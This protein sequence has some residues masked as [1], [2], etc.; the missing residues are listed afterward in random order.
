MN[1]RLAL[2]I[3]FSKPVVFRAVKVAI[4]VG[5]ILAFI[6]HGGLIL[7]KRLWPLRVTGVATLTVSP[8]CR[9]RFQTS[10]K[11]WRDDMR[12]R[13]MFQKKR[14]VT[15]SR[16]LPMQ[17][18]SSFVEAKS[19][20]ETNCCPSGEIFSEQLRVQSLSFVLLCA[21]GDRACEEAGAWHNSCGH[22]WGRLWWV[23]N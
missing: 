14:T 21:L 7:S 18:E 3:F 19:S 10:F 11:W 13:K 1:L 22:R 9:L 15:K 6:N 12:S 8:G 23:T 16:R 5:V 17:R 2:P 20:G 4:I